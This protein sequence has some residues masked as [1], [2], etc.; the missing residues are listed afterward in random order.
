MERTLVLIKPDGI[1][2]GLVG[3]VTR[4]LEAKGLK[5]IGMKMMQLKEALVLEHY[6]HIA[7]KPS[8]AG[9]KNFMQS[10]PVIVQCWEG[11]EAVEAVR[12]IVGITKARSAEA[13]SIRGDLA[14]SVQSN[15][16]HA[17]DS[18]EAALQ[19]VSRFFEEGELFTYDNSEYLHVYSEDER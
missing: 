18:P 9:V 16:V 7:D 1:Q 4:R 15:V 19:E 12:I 13:G 17:S 14:M 10:T 6:A 8:F 2:R 5:L 3:V 11:V